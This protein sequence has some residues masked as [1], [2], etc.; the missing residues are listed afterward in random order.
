MCAVEIVLIIFGAVI[1]TCAVALTI[2]SITSRTSGSRL[3]AIEAAFLFL[4]A[5]VSFIGFLNESAREHIGWLLGGVI[6]AN[7]L[8]LQILQRGTRWISQRRSN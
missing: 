7:V 1:A 4:I 5:A 6:L 2:V 3:V 8:F